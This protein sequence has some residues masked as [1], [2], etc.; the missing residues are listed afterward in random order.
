MNRKQLP[1]YGWREWSPKG[2]GLFV[3]QLKP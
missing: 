3:G 1:G 2:K